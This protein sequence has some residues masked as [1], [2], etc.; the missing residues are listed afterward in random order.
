VLSR[1]NVRDSHGRIGVIWG[2]GVGPMSFFVSTIPALPLARVFPAIVGLMSVDKIV[3]FSV[4]MVLSD[5]MT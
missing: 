3:D 1:L 5:T 2:G 4:S